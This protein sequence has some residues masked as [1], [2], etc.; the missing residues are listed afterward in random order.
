MQK[1]QKLTRRKTHKQPRVRLCGV[2]GE[3]AGSR[4]IYSHNGVPVRTEHLC[5]PDERCIGNMRTGRSRPDG[6][7]HR[8]P[9]GC[10]IRPDSIRSCPD[11]WAPYPSGLQESAVWTTNPFGRQWRSSGRSTLKHQ[12]N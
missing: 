9:G 4:G 5:R 7:T 10:C 1:Y 3:N 6:F 8:P 12:K 11:D 2:Y